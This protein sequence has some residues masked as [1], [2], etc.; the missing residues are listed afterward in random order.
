MAGDLSDR[1]ISAFSRDRASE[2]DYDY[3]SFLFT[4]KVAGD[5]S[6][7]LISA[8]SGDK[9]SG[10]DYDYNSFLLQI[11]WLVICPTD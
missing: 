11:K 4:D 1:L 2:Q 5:L 6:D 9:D 7:R 8:F 3:N 10:Q